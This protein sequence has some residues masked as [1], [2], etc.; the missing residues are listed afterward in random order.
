M[1]KLDTLINTVIKQGA[2]TLTGIF[3]SSKKHQEQV[4]PDCPKHLNNLNEAV[5]D[6]REEIG[7]LQELGTFPSPESFEEVANLSRATKNYANEIA[8]SE[9]YI[10]LVNE[11]I[12]KHKPSKLKID[13]EIMPKCK[14]FTVRI[15]N[16][17]IQR[18]AA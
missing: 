11:Y 10:N 17:K 7:K 8:I 3:E 1:S 5:L 16:A 6:C 18:N 2:S 14:P 15:H 13:Q 9:M 12:Q 4:S